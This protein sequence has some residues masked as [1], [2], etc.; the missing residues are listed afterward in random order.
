MVR[1]Q[2]NLISHSPQKAKKLA[3]KGLRS[4]EDIVADSA[5]FDKLSRSIQTSLKNGPRTVERI[6][7]EDIDRLA[8]LISETLKEFNIYITG[9]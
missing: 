2:Q 5:T 9:S 7:R 4:L 8:L 6:Q 1:T 3:E